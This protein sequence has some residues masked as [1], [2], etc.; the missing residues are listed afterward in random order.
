MRHSAQ[1]GRAIEWHCT[2]ELW[3]SSA[4]GLTAIRCDCMAAFMIK[5]THVLACMVSVIRLR[6]L[7]RAFV[8]GLLL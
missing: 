1:E 7:S 2:G 3:L 4:L 5:T 6:P 8:S